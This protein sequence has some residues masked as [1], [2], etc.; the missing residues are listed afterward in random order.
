[1]LL[2]AVTN[3]TIYF[4]MRSELLAFIWRH[5]QHAIKF[6][7]CINSKYSAAWKGL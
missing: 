3:R 7:K 5:F 2:L 4:L 1:M 6:C